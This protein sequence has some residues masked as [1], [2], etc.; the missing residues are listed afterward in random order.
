MFPTT[1]H[2]LQFTLKGIQ[3][4]DLGEA[5]MF[6]EKWQKESSES[7]SFVRFLSAQLCPAS[8]IN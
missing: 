8:K 6:W 5:L 1:H 2:H 7:N 3:S 4:E